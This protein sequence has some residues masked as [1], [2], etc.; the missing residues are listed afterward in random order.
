M[1]KLSKKEKNQITNETVNFPIRIL[2]HLITTMEQDDYKSFRITTE[3]FEDLFVKVLPSAKILQHPLRVKYGKNQPE[4]DAHAI[5]LLKKS[6]V[7]EALPGLKSDHIYFL[8]QENLQKFIDF[9][10][11]KY[12]AYISAKIETIENYEKPKQKQEFFGRQSK[13]GLITTPLYIISALISFFNQ[14]LVGFIIVV[15]ILITLFILGHGLFQK[16]FGTSEL[17]R[18]SR[19]SILT[20]DKK[21]WEQVFSYVPDNETIELISAE[22]S[23]FKKPQRLRNPEK[24]SIPF[25]HNFGLRAFLKR[26]KLQKYYI[27][28]T[29]TKIKSVGKKT[30][31]IAKKGY[32]KISTGIANI[33]I[34]KPK[35][36]IKIK[37]IGKIKPKLKITNKMKPITH[38]PINTL[39]SKSI[40]SFLED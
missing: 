24:F 23:N 29:A 16:F 13:I 2:R 9:Q 5:I 7:S 8:T 35:K 15:D 30:K 3:I 34:P 27:E 6:L 36:K 22:C 17:Y 21:K 20:R 19:W 40:N 38:N 39:K 1:G 18:I 25:L 4:I 10:D 37:K 11:K 33:S 28:P 31:I 14:D 26:K 32:T 12:K